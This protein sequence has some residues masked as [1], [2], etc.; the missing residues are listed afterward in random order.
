MRSLLSVVIIVWLV[1]ACV[2]SKIIV[3][4][5]NSFDA[6]SYQ[7][8]AWSNEAMT[9]DGRNRFYYNLDRFVRGGITTGLI[10]KGYQEVA[11]PQADLLLTYNFFQTVTPDRGGLISPINE[12]N[13]ARDNGADVNRTSLHNH[14]IPAAIQRG[15]LSL[16]I[17]DARQGKE[18]WQATISKV[19]ESQTDNQ[20]MVKKSVNTLLLKLLRDIPAK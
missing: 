20:S 5:K 9:D 18:V 4:P 7:S 14:Y 17:D 15:S 12:A 1:A 13:A 2:G 10:N 6:A 19:I 3:N 16:S 8:F 11:K